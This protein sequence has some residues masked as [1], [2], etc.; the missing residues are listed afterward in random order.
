MDNIL[1]ALVGTVV[2]ARPW[3]N[4]RELKGTRAIVFAETWLG[5]PEF[6]IAWFP[7]LGAPELGTTVMPILR[8]K[9]TESEPMRKTAPS[10]LLRWYGD[11]RRVRRAGAWRSEWTSG[12]WS[13]EN[14]VRARRAGR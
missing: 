3:R 5:N 9:I 13:V 11:I 1:T 7:S 2:L 10:T 14:E 4:G 6:V 8:H 12:A